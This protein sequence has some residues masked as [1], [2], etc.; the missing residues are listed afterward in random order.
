MSVDS[1]M[2]QL[3]HSQEQSYRYPLSSRLGE[4][5][6][7]NGWF[8][9]EPLPCPAHSLVIT[10]NMLAQLPINGTKSKTK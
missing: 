4:P 6:D 1:L 2:P 10:A 8:F 7:Q 9:E 3:H 5:Q